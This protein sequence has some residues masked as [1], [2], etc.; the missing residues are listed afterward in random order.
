MH[1]NLEVHVQVSSR[2]KMTSPQSVVTI[3]SSS[4]RHTETAHVDDYCFPSYPKGFPL[5]IIYPKCENWS[6]V[7]LAVKWYLCEIY[8]WWLS[9]FKG[10][11]NITFP[12]T[13]PLELCRNWCKNLVGHIFRWMKLTGAWR[14]GWS[15]LEQLSHVSDKGYIIRMT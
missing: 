11:S 1:M 8:S 5:S 10:R 13:I 6:K 12:C 3:N 9:M 14:A 7:S 4:G 2:L 15:K